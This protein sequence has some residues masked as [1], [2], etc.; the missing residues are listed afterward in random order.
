MKSKAFLNIQ[1]LQKKYS[2]LGQSSTN[3]IVG[4]TTTIQPAL[5]S[6]TTSGASRPKKVVVAFSGPNA[7]TEMLRAYS[8]PR[9]SDADVYF[10][11][12]T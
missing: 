3:N 11:V 6:T 2:F 7:T 12:N 9:P 8:A 5:T 1:N 4:P 10:V